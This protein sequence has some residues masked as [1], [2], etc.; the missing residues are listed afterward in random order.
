M[1]KKD[2]NSLLII[3]FIA[4]YIVLSVLF[5]VGGK[6]VDTKWIVLLTVILEFIVVQPSVTKLYYE[7]FGE[8]AGLRFIPVYNE[9]AM[10]PKTIANITLVLWGL[11]A[12]FVAT[13][14]I[15]TNFL[16]QF[17]SANS[18]LNFP[19]RMLQFAILGYIILNVVRGIGFCKV[20]YYVDL[21]HADMLKINMK[22]KVI[23][24]LYYVSA[25][26]PLLRILICLNLK[27]RLYKIV[28]LNEYTAG[29]DEDSEFEEEEE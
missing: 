20:K 17:M 18:A 28:C 9:L 4:A 10:F 15:S 19:F 27:D 6:A 1:T 5:V 23:D 14:F 13:S 16:M 2:K 8:K 22:I 25:F 3:G 21:Q 29:D 12:L 26:I 7:F 11:V 24:Y